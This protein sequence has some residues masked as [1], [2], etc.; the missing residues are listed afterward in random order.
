MVG[1]VGWL[2]GC[3]V[4]AFC[5]VV[6]VWFGLV[7]FGLVWFG[8]CVFVMFVM[9]GLF[10]CLFVCLFVGWLVGWLVGWFGLLV[11]HSKYLI[12]EDVK[13]MAGP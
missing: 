6:F 4:G 1:L 9:F 8:V 11:T 2:V 12:L 10:V 3:L 5:F 13:P 7:W